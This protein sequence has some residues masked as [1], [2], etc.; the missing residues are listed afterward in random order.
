MSSTRWTAIE[1]AFATA[2]EV[3]DAIRAKQISARELLDL[4]FQRIDRHNRALNAIVWENREAAIARAMRADDLLA[5]GGVSGAL[6]GV[7]VTIKEAFA[8]RGSPNTW[9]LPALKD[10]ISPR[11]AVAVERLES[12]GAIVIGKTNVPVMLADWQS[13]NPIHGTTNNPWDVTRTA[14]GST[15]GGAAAVAAGL[16][17]LTLGSDLSG[18]IRIPAHFCGVYGHKPS[19][20]LVSTAGFQP[21]PWDGSPGPPMDLAVVGPLARSARDLAL[22]LSAIGG[23][24]GDPAKAWT[25]RMPL[26]RHTRLQDFRIGY[27][28]DDDLAPV[29]SDV[30]AVHERTLVALNQAGADMVP[31]WPPGVDPQTELGTYQYLLFA[32]VNAIGPQKAPEYHQRWMQETQKR[33]RSRA[34]WQKYFESHDVF[35]C[36]AGFSAAFPHNHSQPLE[37]RVIDTPEGQRPYLNTPLW[38]IFATLAGIPATVAPI[39]RTAAG[40]PVGMQILAPMWEDGTSIEFAERLAEAIGGFVSPAPLASP[41]RR[42]LQ[43]AVRRPAGTPARRHA[44]TARTESTI[45]GR[46]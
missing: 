31:G 15:G 28:M 6:H 34:A 10:A 43:R 16:G 30:A 24:D 42:R 46:S 4:A 2:S 21:G 35:L 14:G 22:T 45:S 19:L 12:A 39:G 36:P 7:P 27:V 33:L 20:G 37:G 18:S 9:G 11:T 23:A 40:L 13:D 5:N 8:Y 29:A 26:P 25:W 38:T 44:S 1:S 3:A 41:G 32:F 17:C